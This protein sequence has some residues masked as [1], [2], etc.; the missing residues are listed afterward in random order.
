[1]K[2]VIAIRKDLNMRKGKMC[3]QAAHA[4]MSFLTRSITGDGR[5][6][7]TDEE[8]EWLETSFRKIVV[9]VQSEEELLLLQTRARKAGLT[10]HLITDN[11]ATE[12]GGAAT[13]TCLAIGPHAD[14]RFIGI[15][16]DLPLL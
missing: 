16:D 3:A 4:S 5:I 8:L 1:M 9:G 7:L 13:R 12:F 2:Q 10:C 11:G 14:G 15:T 6:A